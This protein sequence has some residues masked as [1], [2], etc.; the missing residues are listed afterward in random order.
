MNFTAFDLAT[1]TGVCDCPSGPVPRVFSWHLSDAGEGRPA[2]LLA[3]RR[4]L[5][6]YLQSQPCDRVYFEAPMPIAIMS[7][8]GAQDATVAFLRGAV[9]VLEMT[10]AE[11]G[12]PVEAVN[13]QTARKLVLG[14]AANKSSQ[15]TKARV[16]AEVTRLG[17]KPQTSDEADAA[18]IWYYAAARMNPRLAAA[19]TPLF[20]EAK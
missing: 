11:F 14:W 2:R 15:K 3:L 1:A 12:K 4:A 16:I 10:C 7:R 20:R 5:V 17:V 9:G 19:Y 8:I 6:S 13:V 18:V